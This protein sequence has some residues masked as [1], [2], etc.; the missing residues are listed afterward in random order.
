MKREVEVAIAFPFS[1]QWFKSLRSGEALSSVLLRIS[2]PPP[3]PLTID[4]NSPRKFKD[5]N[6]FLRTSKARVLLCTLSRR[7]P[8][9]KYLTDKELGR[10][11]ELHLTAVFSLSTKSFDPPLILFGLIC[12][13]VTFPERVLPPPEIYLMVFRDSLPFLDSVKSPEANYCLFF[14]PRTRA[15]LPLPLNRR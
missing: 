1:P 8:W 13:F 7:L 10:W 15:R 2:L 14:P 4:A 3:T 11:K 5:F 12:H 6:T 9:W